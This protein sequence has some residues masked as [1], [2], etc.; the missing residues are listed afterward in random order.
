MTATRMKLL[1]LLAG[2][3]F[4]AL[5]LLAWTQEWFALTLLDGAVLSVAG[6]IAA[7][8]LT[9]LALTGLVLV[10]ALSIAGPFFRVILGSLQAL[11]GFTVGL[12]A[13]IAIANPLTSSAAAITAATGVSGASAGEQVDVVAGTAWPWVAL[14]AG[15]LLVV[16]GILVVATARRW[17]GAT[18]KYQAVRLTGVD[19][20]R[21]AVDDWD[22]LS[23]GDDPTR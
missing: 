23:G 1:L 13:V 14:V 12:S 16:T 11:L 22:A 2:I 3:A 10:G 18:R 21:T 7:P 19:G 9:A 15:A 8:A 17:P 4:S 5:T 20:T 6:E